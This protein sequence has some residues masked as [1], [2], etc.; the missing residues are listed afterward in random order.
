[1]LLDL[2]VARSA[3]WAIEQDAF[4]TIL[5][6][7]PEAL[8][9][10]AGRPLQGASKATARGSV[11]VIPVEGP[12]F[13][14]PSFLTSFLGASDY[15]T[16]RQDLQAAIDNPA[17]KGIALNIHSPGG[18]LAGVAELAQAIRAARDVKPIVAY[19]GDLAASAAYW[20]ASAASKI[21]IGSSAGLGSIGV[22]AGYTDTSARDA[23]TGVQSVKIISSQS[24]YKAADPSTDDG[25]TRIQARVDALAD[26]FIDAV[27]SNRGVPR[28]TVLSDFGK[29]DVFIG[30]AAIT[31][32]LAD[33][34][35]SFESVL[36]A[37]AGGGPVSRRPIVSAT[38]IISP[39]T[40][41]A[42]VV[43]S[44]PKPTPVPQLVT[45]EQANAMALLEAGKGHHALT[46]EA[47]AEGWSVEKLRDRA[48]AEDAAQAVLAQFPRAQGQEATGRSRG[49]S[50]D[51]VAA[52]FILDSAALARR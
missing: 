13:R 11:A 6:I 22:I 47:I 23:R 9:A 4:R 16:I 25:R 34:M 2:A 44:A 36:A 52:R 21:V 5:S 26:V 50:D 30:K 24:P 20:I 31:A 45:A 39:V 46:K 32:G 3:D 43:V 28:D 40:A 7:E 27:A 18:Q 41:T 12:L 29:G 19:A 48:E 35:G 33:E 8:A 14:Q 17:V 1:M 51:E 42:P 38:R 15:T 49:T 37:L 10:Y